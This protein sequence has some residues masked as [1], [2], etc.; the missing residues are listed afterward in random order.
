MGSE[1]LVSVGTG[2]S[3]SRVLTNDGNNGQHIAMYSK[4]WTLALALLVSGCSQLPLN[5]PAYRDITYGA[6]EHIALDRRAV[7]HDYVLVDVD[8]IAL[9]NLASSHSTLFSK[10]LGTRSKGPPTVTVGVGDVIQVSVFESGL[11]I[12]QP[13]DNISRPANFVTLPKQTVESSGF[14]TI[15][16][17]G[18]VK[19][20]GRRVSE[21]QSDIEN[22]LA[23]RAVEPHAIISIVEQNASTV[24]VLGDTN[25]ANT[26]KISGSGERILDV[27]SKAGGTKFPGYELF[28][29][30]QRRGHRTTVHFPTLVNDPQANIYVVPGDTIYVHR[31]PEKFVALGALGSTG[32]TQGLTGQF[33]FQ[34]ERLSL[35]EALAKAG[36]LQDARANPTQVFL[37][38]LEYRDALEKM[39]IGLNAF[40]PEQKLIP[41]IYRVNFRD[42]SSFFTAQN[43]QM[44]NRDVI[45]AANSDATEVVKFLGYARAITSTV[46][47]VTT[48]GAVTREI[49]NGASVL[50]NN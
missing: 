49:L 21:I 30:L 29:T 33:E 17:A 50:G 4:G 34:Q 16:Y 22:K 20:A 10:T 39:G 9:E 32:Q 11:G 35:N 12:F 25:G 28:V 3:A 14:I 36:G 41:T 26:V 2:S 19:A 7:V 43:F 6:S 42:P 8:K 27:I 18:R 48:D 45:Y 31:Q 47:G 46:A 15:P 23:Q 24:S 44:R 5:G 37:Y 38:R 13:T 40:P 1:L